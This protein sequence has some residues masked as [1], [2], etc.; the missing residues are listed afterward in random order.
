M[1]GRKVTYWDMTE[2][3]ILSGR[4]YEALLEGGAGKAKQQL[5]FDVSDDVS[6]DGSCLSSSSSEDEETDG[7]ISWSKCFHEPF[8][9]EVLMPRQAQRSDEAREETV[10]LLS[11]MDSKVE[12]LIAKGGIIDQSKVHQAVEELMAEA[13]DR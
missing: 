11:M 7:V 1:D 10:R 4:H 6:E 12:E 5:Q 8:L 3:N 9:E 2:P 13:L